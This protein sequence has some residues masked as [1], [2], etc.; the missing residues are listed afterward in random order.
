MNVR[1]TKHNL[2]F[3]GVF[4]LFF[5]WLAL[6]IPKIRT[7]PG[8][9]GDETIAVDIAQ[10][11][12]KGEFAFGPLHNTFFTVVYQPVYEWLI[13]IGLLVSG[14]DIVGARVVNAMFALLISLALFILGRRI[15]GSK[16][17]IAAAI[18]FLGMEQTIIH[19]RMAYPHNGVT[20][21]L[22]IGMLAACLHISKQSNLL[23]GIGNFL[24]VGSHPIGIYAVAIQTAPRLLHPSSWLM[25]IGIPALLF[26][27]FYMPV[28]YLYGSEIL[29]DAIQIGQSYS[30]Y[31][32]K[33]YGNFIKN[34]GNF[35]GM[36]FFHTSGTIGVILLI[37]KRNICKI[38]IIPAMFLL[39]VIT[40]FTNRSN[41][42]TFYYQATILLPFFSIGCAFL[43]MKISNF[44]GNLIKPQRMRLCW[45][46]V[47]VAVFF[48]LNKIFYV[49]PGNIIPLN[50]F[51]VTQNPLEVEE[52]AHWINKKT[53]N[54]D[55]VIS[56][57]NIWWLINSR[58]ANLLQLTAWD[59]NQ[60]FMHEFGTSQN[61]FRYSLK[62]DKIRFVII[63]D[64]DKRWTLQQPS[65]MSTLV[66]RGITE[67]PIVFEGNYYT[68]LENPN[69]KKP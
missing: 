34:I 2:L 64:I 68:V 27:I 35:I 66:N 50:H 62:N 56:N 4:L 7:I 13:A 43:L 3:G 57:T 38:W 20:L 42:N 25:I 11:L 46:P 22:T 19:F 14:G 26:L 5:L 9:Y 6:Y 29:N 1:K 47:V 54:D 60:T 67:W 65:V 23:V 30:S 15:L 10:N 41:L 51:W 58:K 28:F 59:G 69:F 37:K 36:N 21:G 40:L 17:A 8:W 24:C 45:V 32:A 33:N 48:A 31:G 49:Y 16:C 53:D 52:V 44:F 39:F 12:L 55:V 63:G 61:R 18:F